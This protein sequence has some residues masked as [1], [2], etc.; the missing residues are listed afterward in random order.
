MTFL[1]L[2][3]IGAAV[4]AGLGIVAVVIWFAYTTYLNRL[5]RRLAVRKGLYRDLVAGLANRPRINEIAI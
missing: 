4:L 5:E 1:K 3:L 2:I